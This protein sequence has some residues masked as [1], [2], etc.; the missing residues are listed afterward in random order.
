MVCLSLCNKQDVKLYLITGH[1]EW[2][3]MVTCTIVTYVTMVTMVTIVTVTMVT[4]T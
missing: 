1:D 2:V 3:T 4:S